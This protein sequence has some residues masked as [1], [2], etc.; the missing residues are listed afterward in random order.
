MEALERRNKELEA[1]LNH[2]QQANARLMEELTKMR[3]DSGVMPRSSAPLDFSTSN[4]SVTLLPELFGSQDVRRTSADSP[5]S[6]V[7]D[8]LQSTQSN[9]TVNP[10]SLSPTLSPAPQPDEVSIIH[11]EDV[12]AIK[13][14]PVD[15]SSDLTQRP[16][17]ML[18]DL[19]CHQSEEVSES[20]LASPAT[21]WALYLHLQLLMVTSSAIFSACQRPLMQIAMSLKAGF[22]LPPAQP[23]MKAIIWL[24]TRPSSRSTRSTSTS[25]STTRST[26]PLSPQT[27]RRRSA[28]RTLPW[29]ATTPLTLRLKSLQK[30]LTCSPTLARPL[31]DATM[32]ALRLV[33][34]DFEHRA[35]G[36]AA[37][38]P[39]SRGDSHATLTW[40]DGTP[41]PPREVLLTLLWTLRVEERKMI[42]RGILSSDP[43]PE[44][45]PIT[46]TGSVT[47]AKTKAIAKPKDVSSA[48]EREERLRRSC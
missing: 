26:R 40:L 34:E 15:V 11:H 35:G 14:E 8:L 17:A 30:I 10:A 39:V 46:P 2:A 22:S 36:L 48:E 29:A 47:L 43:R 32:E 13:A 20:R 21:M 6:L 7:D 27:R 33:S 12:H 45:N 31:M 24:V 42:R 28:L 41:F 23:I 38:W 4:N 25:S 44:T 1:A 3:R 9:A 19:Q 5:I 18:C 37:A 16:A